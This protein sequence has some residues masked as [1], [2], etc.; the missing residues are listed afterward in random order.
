MTPDSNNGFLATNGQQRQ[1][2]RQRQG[3]RQRQREGEMK[4]DQEDR[5][6][7]YAQTLDRVLLL[8]VTAAWFRH[9]GY[10]KKGNSVRGIY[11]CSVSCNRYWFWRHW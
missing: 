1:R 10:M 4:R 8:H 9:I 11:V 6:R 3:Q 2:Q 5:E 7:P